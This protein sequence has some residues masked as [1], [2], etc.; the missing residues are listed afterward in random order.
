MS[1]HLETFNKSHV[2]A[3]LAFSSNSPAV[4]KADWASPPLATRTQERWSDRPDP[5]T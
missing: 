2:R 1:N 3:T 5:T 4:V